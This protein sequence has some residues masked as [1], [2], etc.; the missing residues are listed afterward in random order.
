M[1]STVQSSPHPILER[2]EAVAPQIAAAA[3]EIEQT[4]ELPRPLFEALADAGLFHL[5][6]PRQLGGPELDFPTFVQALEVLARADAST[7]WCVSQNGIFGTHAVCVAPSVAREI[8]FAQPRSVVANTP[9]PTATA[10]AVEGGYLVTGRQPYSTGCRHANWIAARGFVLENG[11][12]RLAEGGRPDMRFFLIP[13]EEVQILDTWHT[14]GLRGT[15]TH[16]FEI[17]DHFVPE[18]RS[19][20]PFGPPRP[21]Y[22]LLYQVPRSLMFAAGDAVV[23][24]GLARNA[25]DQFVSIAHKKTPTYRSDLVRDQQ[26]VQVR[27]GEAEALLS[28]ARAYLFEQVRLAWGAI[29]EQGVLPLV[30]RVGLRG[31]TTFTLRKTADVVDTA[32]NLAGGTVVLE[33]HPLQRLFQDVHVV[34]QHVQAREQHY[35]LIGRYLLGLETDAQFV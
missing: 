29:Q 19:F 25:L 9:L 7:A 17:R 35:E 10:V 28:A 32:Y 6:T 11:A 33:S 2:V 3:D 14:R 24:L 15:G 30:N 13:T 18:H 4:R 16:D 12:P 31:A 8:W 26:Y 1:M 23:G 5:L 20:Y 22:G 34:T 27:L 21:E